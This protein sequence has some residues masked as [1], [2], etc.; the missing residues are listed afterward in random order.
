M[1]TPPEA[2]G[3]TRGLSS[4]LQQAANTVH[5]AEVVGHQAAHPVQTA[6]H[7]STDMKLK[8]RSHLAN[9]FVWLTYASLSTCTFIEEGLVV[10]PTAY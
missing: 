5:S 4:M 8:A 10:Y 7:A 9:C 1:Q 3:G 2:A 6:H